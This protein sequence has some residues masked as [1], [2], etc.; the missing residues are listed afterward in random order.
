MEWLQGAPCLWLL[1]LLVLASLGLLLTRRRGRVERE[2]RSTAGIVP[3]T[4]AEAAVRALQL[5]AWSHAVT[6]RIARI[7]GDR[8]TD[9]NTASGVLLE[10]GDRAVI[11]TAWHVLEGFRDLRAAGETVA[12]VCDNMPIPEPRTAYRDEASDLALFDVPAQG[13]RGLKAVPYRP[14]HHW[15]PPAVSVGDDV[16]LC[17]FPKL[18]RHDGDEIL[19]GDLNLL[20]T[21]ASAADHYFM[22]QVDWDTMVQAGRVRIRS[23]Q[24]DFGGASG[25]PVF[26]SDQGGNPLVGVILQT[27]D[28]L[29]LWRV[30]AL[31]AVP[32]VEDWGPSQPV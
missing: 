12:L 2:L 28:T 24:A 16:L 17:G 30:A 5:R 26:L 1:A 7:T 4:Q 22:L 6:I 11:A 3:T 20:L 9:W 27:G 18:F 21:V 31:A 29:P 14:G 15:P 13:R 23:G 8:E 10:I 19:H 32:G 25:G